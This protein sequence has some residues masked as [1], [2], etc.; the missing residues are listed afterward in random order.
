MKNDGSQPPI[1]NESTNGF[2]SS[3]FGFVLIQ[4]VVEL[5]EALGVRLV[6]EDL[7][8]VKTVGHLIE[9]VQKKKGA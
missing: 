1:A 7:A 8:K 3:T 2:Q 6:Q 9:A 5:Q 4:M